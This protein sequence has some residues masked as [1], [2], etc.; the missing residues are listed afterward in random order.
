VLDIVVHKNVRLSDVIVAGVLDS[1]HLPVVFH[2]PHHRRTRNT[3]DPVDI[4]TDWERFQIFT[5]EGAD[6]GVRD[7]TAS[8]TSA[9]RLPTSKITLSDLNKVLGGLE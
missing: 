1:G 6:T 8:T 2:L 5:W 4:F 9:Y 3:S 7:I